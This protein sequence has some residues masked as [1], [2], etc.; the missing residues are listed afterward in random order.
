MEVRLFN[1]SYS[2]EEIQAALEDGHQLMDL[3]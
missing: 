1:E 2:E 3:A